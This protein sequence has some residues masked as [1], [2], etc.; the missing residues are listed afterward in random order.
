MAALLQAPAEPSPTGDGII[1]KP[2]TM[3]PAAAYFQCALTCA[4]CVCMCSCCTLQH[5]RWP[6]CCMGQQVGVAGGARSHVWPRSGGVRGY[7]W[8]SF[9]RM[10]R[11]CS[12]LT[13]TD[14]NTGVYSAPAQCHMLCL[15]CILS[16]Q[17]KQ[18]LA[19]TSVHSTYSKPITTPPT[20]PP[21]SPSLYPF[22]PRQR[23]T[24]R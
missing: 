15:Q 19:I 3:F 13:E 16:R 2:P 24:M 7:V 6:L 1:L 14:A 10:L 21:S 23:P 22:L 4:R 17:L 20:W 5:M 12:S 9:N 8:P 18:L 11:D